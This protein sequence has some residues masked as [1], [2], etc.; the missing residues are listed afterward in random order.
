MAEATLAPLAVRKLADRSVERIVR[1]NELTGEKILI[2]PETGQPSPYPFAGLAVEG[3]VP[4]RTRVSTKFIVR[5]VSEGWI[6]VAGTEL[7]HRPGGPPEDPWATTHTFVHYDTVTLKTVDG[8]L[9]YK[10]VR[11]P[12][13]YVA[14][15]DE[16]KVTEEDYNSGNTQVDW[17]YELELE[18]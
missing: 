15:D 10:V 7:A 11:Q 4:A 14:G 18:V 2:D 6:E 3:E 8:D 12:D 17:F 13:K 1:Y 5:G 9:V 16:A